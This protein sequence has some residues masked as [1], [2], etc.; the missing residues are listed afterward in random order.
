MLVPMTIPDY[1]LEEKRVIAWR[2]RA[3]GVTA[4]EISERYGWG[5]PVIYSWG[6]DEGDWGE[7]KRG[8]RERMKLCRTDPEIRRKDNK[9][10]REWR[11]ENRER[12][13][14]GERKQRR[15]HPEW[16]ERKNKRAREYNRLNR[17]KIAAKRRERY[18]ADP[19]FRAKKLSRV[20][21]WQD[22]HPEEHRKRSRDWYRK[23]H[24]VDPAGGANSE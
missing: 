12:I 23:K 24:N 21:K 10:R 9:R 20:Q 19:E 14:T 4:R 7:R 11:A 16:R 18:Q 2:L 3:E 15:D 5:R 13:L 8:N 1:T 22:D 17:G 6:R